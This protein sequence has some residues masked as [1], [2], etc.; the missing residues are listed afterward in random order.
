M[1]EIDI[2]ISRYTRDS[3]AFYN[4]CRSVILAASKSKP[5]TNRWFVIKQRGHVSYRYHRRKKIN[6]YIFEP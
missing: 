5:I 4:A 6:I 3:C 1:D 2:D